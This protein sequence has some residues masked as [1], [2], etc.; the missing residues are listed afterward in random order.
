MALIPDAERLRAIEAAIDRVEAALGN[1]NVGQVVHIADVLASILQG[2]GI[3]IDRSVPN[4]ITVNA[5]GGVTPPSFSPTSLAAAAVTF[6]DATLKS[7]STEP[8]PET[9]SR[10]LVDIPLIGTEIWVRNA[11]F[12]AKAPAAV[13]DARTAANATP[14]ALVDIHRGR[15]IRFWLARTVG[16]VPLVSYDR[17]RAGLAA[18]QVSISHV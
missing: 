7:A 12:R 18:E 15:E 10:V 5:T 8:V 13:G 1:I 16:Y 9:A 4:Q 14:L 3:T 6:N 2:T 17:G 11:K